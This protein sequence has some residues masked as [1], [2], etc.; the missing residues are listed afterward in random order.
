MIKKALNRIKNKLRSAL[1]T[2][3]YHDAP[4]SAKKIIFLYNQHGKKIFRDKK[5]LISA[6]NL[7]KSGKI[8][9]IIPAYEEHRLGAI[10]DVLSYFSKIIDNKNILIIDADSKD[11]TSTYVK[12][13]G[14]R[15]VEQH[16]IEECLDLNRIAKDFKIEIPLRQGKGK[17]LLLTNIYQKLNYVNDQVKFNLY[18]DADISNPYK[19]NHAKYLAWVA[20]LYEPEKLLEVKAAQHNRNNQSV[21]NVLGILQA[22]NEVINNYYQVIR[23]MIWP[24]TGQVM[25]SIQL[26]NAVPNTL[27]FS[28]EMIVNVAVV[29]FM[30][31]W[32]MKSAQIEISTRCQDSKN[33]DTKETCMMTGIGTTLFA[34][35]EIWFKKGIH[36]INAKRQHYSELNQYLKFLEE[37]SGKGFFASVIHEATRPN[38]II[39]L[40]LDRLL[41]S[42]NYLINNG[43]VDVKKVQSLIS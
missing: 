3:Q 31:L 11:K 7:L 1:F 10:Y 27:G 14:Y 35:N 24:L 21:M 20:S 34:M 32:N 13:L 28:T 23:E 40:P 6:K 25:R 37:N 19:F 17:T 2:D 9:V 39:R 30:K 22:S 33:S 5:K 15:V 38:E 41:P 12:K 29:D 26:V 43:Y 18:S 4:L 36:L 42:V 16:C 8:R